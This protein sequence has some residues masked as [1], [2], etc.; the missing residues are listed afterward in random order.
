ML[1]HLKKSYRC[2]MKYFMPVILPYLISSCTSAGRKESL[3]IRHPLKRLQQS[4]SQY[5][6]ASYYAAGFH[7]RHTAAGDRYDHQ[8]Y[9]AAHRTL[10][11]GT[12]LMVRNTVN[13]KSV[14]VKVNDRGPFKPGRI[15]DLSQK[16]FQEISDSNKDLLQVEITVLPE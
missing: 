6:E 9:T 15:I 12:I 13:D 16:A 4:Y 3:E 8:Q 14:K 7:G 5:G 1:K 11:F 10:P 2:T